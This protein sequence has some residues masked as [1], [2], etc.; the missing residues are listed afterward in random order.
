MTPRLV[1]SIASCTTIAHSPRAKA[2]FIASFVKFGP[3][4]VFDGSGHFYVR[5]DNVRWSLGLSETL[6]DFDTY[7]QWA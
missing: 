7:L 3:A 6:F 1:R 2:F 5:L 4:L